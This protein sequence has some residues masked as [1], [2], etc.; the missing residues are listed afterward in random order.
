MAEVPPRTSRYAR[1]CL[2]EGGNGLLSEKENSA[3][4]MRVAL[5]KAANMLDSLSAHAKKL[6]GA[7]TGTRGN[8]F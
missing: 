4:V 5:R 7:G 1:G 3:E 8:E 2:R 6:G